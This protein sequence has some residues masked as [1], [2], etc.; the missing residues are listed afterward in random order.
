[1]KNKLLILTLVALTIIENCKASQFSKKPFAPTEF[2]KT[3]Y[4]NVSID[5]SFKNQFSKKP[6]E[7]TEFGKNIYSNVSIVV[8][9]AQN[10][11]LEEELNQ[12]DNKKIIKEVTE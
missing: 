6:F 1:M 10:Q 8:V 2:G 3:I 4:S 12:F 11:S 7:P 9:I 5:N